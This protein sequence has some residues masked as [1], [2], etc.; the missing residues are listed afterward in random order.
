MRIFQHALQR[1]YKEIIQR[2]TAGTLSWL[3]AP[4]GEIPGV[5]IIWLFLAV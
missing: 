5:K 3:C 1:G 2:D 4:S